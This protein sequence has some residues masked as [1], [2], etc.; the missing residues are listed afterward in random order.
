MS[1]PQRSI[2]QLQSALDDAIG[3]TEELEDYLDLVRFD[4]LVFKLEELIGEAE[5]NK[6][7]SEE[8]EEGESEDDDEEA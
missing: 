4:E 8:D 5:T 7:D 1:R 3:A 2:S 6:A